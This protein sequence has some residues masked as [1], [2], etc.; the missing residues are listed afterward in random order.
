M[1][2]VAFTGTVDDFPLILP[3]LNRFAGA[4]LIYRLVGPRGTHPLNDRSSPSIKTRLSVQ[5]KHA[6]H[7]HVHYNG[8]FDAFTKIFEQEGVAG[9]Y[10][11]IAS[12]L[13]NTVAQNFAYFYWYGF[14]RGWW[15]KRYPGPISTAVELLLGAVA[16][17]ISQ[18]FTLPLAV[19]STRQQTAPRADKKGV[20]GTFWDIVH[21]E[22][23]PALW[24][25]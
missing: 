4:I 13:G 9:L 10:A 17:A 6:Y 11:G 15:Q 24:K 20:V 12:T 1:L 7:G 19:I 3:F 2:S 22:G 16:G 5:T 21:N 8:A 14:I 18:M 25:G 23:W